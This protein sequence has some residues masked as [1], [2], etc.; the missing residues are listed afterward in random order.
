MPRPCPLFTCVVLL[1]ASLPALAAKKQPAT[2]AYVETSYLIAPRQIGDFELEGSSYDPG[3]K[4]SGAGFRYALKDHQEIRFDVYVYPAGRM[5]QATAVELGMKAFRDDLK[6][7]VNQGSYTKLQELQDSSF[8]LQAATVASAPANDIDAAVIKAKAEAEQVIG[9]KLQLSMNL[10]P[11]DWPMYSSGYL[12]YK[13]LY[14]FKL[15]ASAAQERITQAS[16]DTLAD[17]AARAL[18]PALQV[19]N[20]GD[21][22]N[23]TIYL[24]PDASTE[25][26]AMAVVQQTTLHA[27]YNCHSSTDEAGLPPSGSGMEIVEIG[28]TANEWKSQ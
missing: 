4:Y 27:G 9:R 6:Q 10:Q 28:Y 26:G 18:I 22:A 5:Q 19:A 15:R 21:C 7:A 8:P 12:F 2:R 1:A 17:H 25:T 3:Q 11:R 14:Y 16:F 24:S 23:A 13:Q 20:I